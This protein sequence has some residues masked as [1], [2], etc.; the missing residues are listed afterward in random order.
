[1][2]VRADV[3]MV[4]MGKPAA[5]VGSIGL[6]HLK[7]KEGL[8]SAEDLKFE[9]EGGL[10]KTTKR[11]TEHGRLMGEVVEV[12]EVV[13]GAGGVPQP[14]HTFQR[15][16]SRHQVPRHRDRQRRGCAMLCSRQAERALHSPPP[17]PVA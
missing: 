1:M 2:S 3:E 14:R 9:K 7:A 10:G 13:A 16:P 11:F 6:Q 17:P 5:E 12:V 8:K 4:G 15:D